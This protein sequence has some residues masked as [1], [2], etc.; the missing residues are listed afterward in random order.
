MLFAGQV[1]GPLALFSN[2]APVYPG[3]VGML[4]AGGGF[5]QIGRP[6]SR[7]WGDPG[8]P[9]V[10]GRLIRLARAAGVAQGVRGTTFGR[11]GGR[12]MGMYTTVAN[13]DQWMEK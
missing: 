13:T 1:S 7:V 2:I 12:R 6:H 11:I 9:A 3:M 4:A 5:D 10:A 8:D